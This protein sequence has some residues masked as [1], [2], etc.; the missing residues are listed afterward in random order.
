MWVAIVG[1]CMAAGALVLGALLTMGR[2]EY[3]RHGKLR[4]R[5]GFEE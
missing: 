3:D 5:E 1:L 4:K 2:G